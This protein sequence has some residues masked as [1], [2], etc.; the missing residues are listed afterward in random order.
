MDVYK[1][2]LPLHYSSTEDFFFLHIC[3]VNTEK[4]QNSTKRCTQGELQALPESSY[5]ALNTTQKLLC[6]NQVILY[7]KISIPKKDYLSFDFPALIKTWNL[8]PYGDCLCVIPQNPS[9]PL[10]SCGSIGLHQNVCLQLPCSLT[11]V[12]NDNSR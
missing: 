3:S 2:I 1:Q 9:L 11:C 10:F 4:Q 6:K 7:N 12:V 5:L 8:Q